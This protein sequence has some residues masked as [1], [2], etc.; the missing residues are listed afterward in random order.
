MIDRALYRVVLWAYPA[1]YRA[2]Y[3]GDMLETFEHESARV[4]ARG[5]WSLI[6]FWIVTI[7]QALWF[8]V[9]E[10]RHRLTPTGAPMPPHRFRFSLVP[11]VRYALR[12][13]MRSPVFAVTSV[14]SLA[15]GLAATTVIFTLMDAFVFQSS[16]GVGEPAR[17]VDIGR[18]TE[19]EGFDNMPYPTFQY[20]RDHTQTLEAMAATTFDPSPMSLSTGDSSERLFAQLVSW[21][22]FDVLKLRPAA[23]RFFRADEDRVAEANPVVVEHR[24]PLPEDLQ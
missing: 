21:S 1:Q 24:P 7:V 12:L 16:P 13:L 2:R 3:A 19:G 9:A 18:S 23:G 4:R 6:P 11:D 8:G 5:W 17:V 15:L 10:R 20:L 14:V 22:Y